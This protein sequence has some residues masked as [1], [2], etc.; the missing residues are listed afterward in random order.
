MT[1]LNIPAGEQGELLQW[2]LR[3][4]ELVRATD[5]M[6]YTQAA[7]EEA[8]R[9]LRLSLPGGFTAAEARAALGTTRRYVI[10]ITEFLS[11]GG[12]TRFDG[13]RHYWK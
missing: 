8:E 4:G 10:P 13:E 9:L 2:F 7:M 6:V 11:A 3:C 12:I 1:E 5:A